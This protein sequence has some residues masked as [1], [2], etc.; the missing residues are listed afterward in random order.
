MK[1]FDGFGG[2][3]FAGEISPQVLE[4]AQEFGWVGDAA[5]FDEVVLGFLEER[6][7]RIRNCSCGDDVDRTLGGLLPDVHYRGE[8]FVD[9]LYDVS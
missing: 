2:V 8:D 9:F 5:A 7:G 1:C 4:G 3:F 6:E